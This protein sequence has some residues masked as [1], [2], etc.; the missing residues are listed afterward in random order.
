M[1]RQMAMI[2]V[3]LLVAAV[4]L[5]AKLRGDWRR[6][7]QR[8]AALAAAG[9][10][11]PATPAPK[12][13]NAAGGADVETIARRNLFSPD[14][15]SDLPKEAGQRK[16]PPE[17]IVI[18]T[19]NVGN[20]KIALMAEASAA[21]GT[22]SRQVREGETFGGYRVVSIGD[23][24]VTLEFEG[25]QTKVEVYTAAQEVPAPR[26]AAAD[27]PAEPQRVTT[28]ATVPEPAPLP[29]SVTTTASS[30][31]AGPTGQVIPGTNGMFG[32]NDNLPAGTVMGNYRKVV[33]P[34]PF[35]NQVWWEPIG[36]DERKP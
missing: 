16:A 17:P 29:S 8:Y 5:A 34:T 26:I 13:A 30:G 31:K 35:G 32:Y 7:N 1:R 12:A 36:A 20:G 23:S 21:I 33:R 3:V 27:R 19:L 6:A 15:N 18:G 2:N 28:T 10:P 9:Q 24:V 22:V 25:R 14:R 11:S 4:V